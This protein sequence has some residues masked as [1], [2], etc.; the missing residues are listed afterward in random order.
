MSPLAT[1]SAEVKG[2]GAMF[3]ALFSMPKGDDFERF[4]YEAHEYFVSGTANGQPYTHADRHS[5]AGG[6]IAVTA[7]SMLAESMH[8]S[9]N[10]W[11]FHFTH[12]LHDDS[13]HIGVEILTS[14]TA[15]VRSSSTPKRYKRLAGGRRAGGRDHRAGRR[16]AEIE[17]AARIRCAAL[18]IR[19]MILAGTSASA[20][21]LVQLSAGAHGA[22]G[23][24]DMKPIYD[25][26]L[27]TS[28]G[29]QHPTDRRADDSRCR[30]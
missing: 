27:P 22:I 26:F 15:A 1:I 17:A 20:A 24:P 21:V 9:G 14:A 6:R 25:G 29:A 8:P 30:R 23:S 2:P 7:A 19:K 28:T 5:Q 18:P 4:G 16:A 11:M 10:A 3:P 13:G 12:R